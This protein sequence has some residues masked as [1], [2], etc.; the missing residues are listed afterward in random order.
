MADV[1]QF[2]NGWGKPAARRIQWVLDQYG[3]ARVPSS[4]T[5]AVPPTAGKSIWLDLNLSATGFNLLDDRYL[6]DSPPGYLPGTYDFTAKVYSTSEN[7]S[8]AGT[9]TMAPNATTSADSN[10]LTRTNNITVSSG[11][12]TPVAGFTSKPTTG[13]SPVT[14]LGEYGFNDPRRILGEQGYN[15]STLLEYVNFQLVLPY[16]NNGGRVDL[17]ESATGNV[18]LSVNISKYAAPDTFM[19]LANFTAIPTAGGVPLTVIFTDSSLNSPALWYWTFGD[20]S[21]VNATSQNPVHTYARVGTYT[22]SLNATNSAGSNTFTRTDYITVSSGPTPTLTPTHTPTL[23]PTPTPTPTTT[24][25]TIGMYWNGVYYLRNTNTAGNADLAFTYGMQGDIPVTGDWIG[26]GYDSIGMYRNGVYYLRNTN[27]AGNA[28]LTFTYG[29]QGDI[30]VTGDWTGK[31]YDSIGMY[32][33]GVYYL[34][35]TNTAGNADLTF[36]YGMQGDIPVTGDWTGKGYDSIGMYR[37]GV[38]YLRNSNT[39]GNA[40]LTFTYGTTGDIPVTGDWNGDGINT[41][42]M[43]RNGVYY[44]RNTNTAGNADLT[45]TYGMQGDKPVTGKWV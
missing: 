18:K 34:R 41:I 6:T 13:T 5:A 10:T 31:G 24:T 8:S 45:F 36:T 16:F 26:K 15:G 40:D 17:I 35:N 27:T 39:A 38:F 43:Y 4:G 3:S 25:S 33:N 22:V 32:R 12:V 2:A 20:G 7:Y 28:D 44:L 11:R 42:G 14:L 23:T 37:N 30:P 19:P 1:N 21:E 9:Y 29:M